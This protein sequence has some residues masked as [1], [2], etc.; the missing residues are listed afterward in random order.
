MNAKVEETK[1]DTVTVTIDGREVA[2][3]KGATIIQ[4]ADEQGIDIPRFCYHRKLS[5]PANCRMCLVDVEM[6][7]RPAPKPLPACATAVGDGMTVSTQSERALKAQRGV[8][9]FLLINHPLDCPICDQGGECELQDVSMGYGRSVSRFVERK[10]SVKDEDLGPLVATEMTRCIHCTRCV[11][12]L[13][14]IA[15]TSEL[16]GM[17]RGEH[18]EIG[19]WVGHGVH[20]ELSGNIIDLCPVGALTNKPFRFRARAWEMLSHPS[21]SPHDPVGANLNLHHVRGTIKRVVPRENESVNENWI[22]DRD[23][24]GYQGVYSED[25]LARPMI[26][27]DGQ[28]RETDWETALEHTVSALKSVVSRHGGEA[29]GAL[30]SPSATTE[31]MYLL[32]RLVRDL[33]SDSIDHRLRQADFR[34]DDHA[35][36]R[37]SLGRPIADF[38]SV[39]AAFVVGGYPR[40][41]VPLL[42]H[43]LRQ[44]SLRGGDVMFLN[45]RAHDWNFRPTLEHV[46][47]P[48]AMVEA[49]AAVAT[50]L[51]ESRG[52]SLPQW[53][54]A[55]GATVGDEHRRI[56]DALAN[57][58]D[59]AVLT[60][61]LVEGHPAGAEL[62]ALAAY[63]A[64][65]AG[66]S[67]GVLTAG[68]NSAGGWLAGAVPHRQVGGGQGRGRDAGA[69][70]REGMSG[71]ITLG[72]EPEH[73]FWNGAAA[74]RA[75][76]EAEFAL[77]L[78]PWATPRMKAWAD[79]ILPVASF[80]ETAGTLV[81]AQGDWQT[82][83]GVGRPVGEARPAWRL[84]RVLGNLLDLDGYD[85]QAPDEIHADLRGRVRGGEPDM[86]AWENDTLEPRS[87]SGLMRAG[88][89]ALYGT[90]ALVRR[91]EALQRT[92]QARPASAVLAP[93]TAAALGIN[94]GETV[95]VRQGEATSRLTVTVDAAVPAETVWV[96][97]GLQGSEAL[98]PLMGEVTVT[99]V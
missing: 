54:A 20:S 29:L 10:R 27:L 55:Y 45:P 37:P 31:E 99:R 40:W 43:R 30:I 35:P 39:D 88:G 79:V 6:N 98:G 14:E 81:N 93:A 4:V 46:V 5:V 56:A 63:V 48:G 97:A 85:Y 18:M 34:D 73:D 67:F 96:D 74:E 68:G 13:D 22:A 42:N 60:G 80:G 1:P 64:R 84:L 33:G 86:L 57:A 78:S 91:G 82:F 49:A 61:G 11:R 24:F 2:A 50:A 62:R 87:P 23:R 51:A 41:E 95:E 83:A 8:M 7:G 94:E 3:P 70:I 71:F 19:T 9:E 16:G 53:V 75:L 92:S 26:K 47:H 89:V 21:V 28:W 36:E 17:Y 66:A 38:E 72:V 90:D 52:E 15:G 12:F 77:A 58:G 44:A 65:T 59:A 32:A 76:G 25:R 69:M